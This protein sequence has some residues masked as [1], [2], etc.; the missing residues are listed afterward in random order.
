MALSTDVEDLK[1]DIR[2]IDVELR[3][4]NNRKAILE[5]LLKDAKKI[6]SK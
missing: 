1:R 5:K 3:I 2:Y 6:E 4:L